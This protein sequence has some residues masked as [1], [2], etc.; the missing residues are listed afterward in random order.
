MVAIV[1]LVEIDQPQVP[2]LTYTQADPM[3]SSV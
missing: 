2:I 3:L 1:L